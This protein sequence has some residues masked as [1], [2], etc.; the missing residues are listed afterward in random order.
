MDTYIPTEV[1][2]ERSSDPPIE[3]EDSNYY[4]LL[5]IN[6]DLKLDQFESFVIKTKDVN[7]FKHIFLFLPNDFTAS[8]DISQKP[9]NRSKNRFRGYYPYDYSRVVLQKSKTDPHSDY[10]NANYID[11]YK[12]SKAYIAAQG[13]TK[14]TIYDFVRM[15]W[16]QKCDKV[17]MLTNVQEQGK[18]KCEQYWPE[19]GSQK[20]GEI[21]LTLNEE[22][23]RADFTVRCITMSKGTETHKFHHFHYTSWPDHDVPNVSDLLDFL[24]MV[25]KHKPNSNKPQIVHCS[26]GVGRTGTYIAIDCGLKQGKETGSFD[27]IEFTKTM[28]NQRKGMIQTAGQFQFVFEALTQGFKY[29]DTRSNKAVYESKFDFKQE[30]MQDGTLSLKTQYEYL[31]QIKPETKST[32]SLDSHPQSLPVSFSSRTN[33]NGYIVAALNGYNTESIWQLIQNKQCSVVVALLNSEN[34]V[35]ICPEAG[36]EET[37]GSLKLESKTD[38]GISEDL[39]IICVSTCQEGADAKSVQVLIMNIRDSRLFLPLAKQMKELI[40]QIDIQHCDANHP[41]AVFSN[42]PSVGQL[43]CVIR[44]IIQRIKLDNEVEIFENVRKMHQQISCL[45]KSED[46]YLSLHRFAAE[47]VKSSSVYAN[48]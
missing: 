10:I 44:N 47:Y 18:I 41:I 23:A 42:E 16:E 37:F 24:Y 20:F 39:N 12:Q 17:V 2:A 45:V 40:E 48:L 7:G 36:T 11:G 15:I 6:T 32:D 8:Y 1:Q 25:N 5:N 13:A 19:K 35:A 3:S 26:A 28:R 14:V 4:N 31:R 22:R 33:L 38:V 34:E 27:V 9:E 46:E 29:G 21:N 30:P 43:F